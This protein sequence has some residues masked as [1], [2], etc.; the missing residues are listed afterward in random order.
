MTES[1]GAGDEGEPHI[2]AVT[3]IEA[4]VYALSRGLTPVGFPASGRS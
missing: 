4:Q 2:K 1:A 3:A